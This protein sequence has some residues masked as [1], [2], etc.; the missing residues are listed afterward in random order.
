MPSIHR[1]PKTLNPSR[2]LPDPKRENFAQAVANGMKPAEA[3]KLAGFTGKSAAA[4]WQ[5]RHAPD[6][7]ARVEELL[8]AR[9]KASARTF[10]RRQK[11]TGDLLARSIKE[12]EAI[13]FQDVRE[14]VDWRREPVTSPDGSV[15]IEDRLT[16][17]DSAALPAEAAKAVKGVFLKSGAVRLEMHDKRAALETLIKTLTGAD[18]AMQTPQVTV[19]QVNIGSM[20]ALDVARRVSFLLAKA[21]AERARLPPLIEGKA[22]QDRKSVV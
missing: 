6:I 1:K 19:N 4:T 8:D 22:V 20:S 16:I 7:V 10:A 18:A 17:R 12:L 13:A 21:D 5:L 3:H 2:P 15:T 14:L 11:K 9:V